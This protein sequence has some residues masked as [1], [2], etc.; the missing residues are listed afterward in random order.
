MGSPLIGC[1]GCAGN[2][3]SFTSKWWRET[4]TTHHF[5]LSVYATYNSLYLLT[6]LLPIPTWEFIWGYLHG[7]LVNTFSHTCVWIN[8][9]LVQ[10]FIFHLVF[11]GFESNQ[12][13]FEKNGEPLVYIWLGT[14]VVKNSLWGDSS[15]FMLYHFHNSSL[16]RITCFIFIN[17]RSCISVE[18]KM[19]AYEP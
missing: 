9:A 15:I 12:R 5:L 17:P 1:C 16:L 6:F 2:K 13:S 19:A 7:L 18:T 4:I 3:L 10:C 8:A 14:W 11:R